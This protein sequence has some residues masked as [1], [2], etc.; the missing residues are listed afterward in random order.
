VRNHCRAN[1]TERGSGNIHLSPIGQRVINRTDENIIRTLIAYIGAQYTTA[2][3]ET[4]GF[5]RV[6]FIKRDRYIG[7]EGLL[8]SSTDGKHEIVFYFPRGGQRSD[9]THT[10]AWGIDEDFLN[11][12][13]IP[14]FQPNGR[15]YERA[16]PVPCVCRLCRW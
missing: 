2:D 15:L 16:F 14:A 5:K 8:D 13:I 4:N 1:R 12:R 11:D 7:A 9:D 6:F 10:N 3:F